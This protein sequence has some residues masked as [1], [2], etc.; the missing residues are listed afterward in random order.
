MPAQGTRVF[1]AIS[2]SPSALP[3]SP[4]GRSGRVR[5]L[6]VRLCRAGPRGPPLPTFHGACQAQHLRFGRTC[7]AWQDAKVT[8]AVLRALRPPLPARG[9]PHF[10]R[11]SFRRCCSSTLFA[12]S[13]LRSGSSHAFA[14]AAWVVW[15]VQMSR[16]QHAQS[17]S[18]RND[19]SICDESL[20]SADLTVSSPSLGDRNW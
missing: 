12:R 11:P 10:R 18:E 8:R 4:T 3:S 9:A 15:Y 7:P 1:S 17:P 6:P 5:R 2:L 13:P 14:L 19:S 16:T 20:L